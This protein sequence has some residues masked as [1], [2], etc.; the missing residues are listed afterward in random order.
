MYFELEDEVASADF[1]FQ[2]DRNAF[3]HAGS[4]RRDFHGGLVGL[5]GDQRLV[6][7]D[8]VA[9]LDQ[10]LNDLGLARRTDVRNMNVLNSGSGGCSRCGR[11]R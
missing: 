10:Q 1:V 7:F 5:Q 4:R 3:H 8:G 6:G 2:L 9:D 11:C